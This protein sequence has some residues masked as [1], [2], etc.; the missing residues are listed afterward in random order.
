ML[1][2]RVGRAGGYEPSCG[3]GDDCGGSEQ[4]LGEL[5]AYHDSLRTW[6]DVGEV[7]P[8]RVQGPLWRAYKVV[9]TNSVVKP[10]RHLPCT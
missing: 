7:V 5:C 8:V 9:Q 2:G 3:E 4:P 1:L 6:G 10:E